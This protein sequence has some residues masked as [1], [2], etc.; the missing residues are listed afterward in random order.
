MAHGNQN[1]SNTKNNHHIFQNSTKISKHIFENKMSASECS[2]QYHKCPFSLKMSIVLCKWLPSRFDHLENIYVP[3]S[4]RKIKPS[5]SSLFSTST[6]NLSTGRSRYLSGLLYQL[7][8]L[9]VLHFVQHLYRLYRQ[10]LLLPLAT[11]FFPYHPLLVQYLQF[12]NFLFCHSTSACSGV[13]IALLFSTYSWINVAPVFSAIHISRRKNTRWWHYYS[14]LHCQQFDWTK[15]HRTC[16]IIDNIK[17]QR[18]R[19]NN[20]FYFR[21]QGLQRDRHHVTS[22]MN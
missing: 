17:R 6:I 13:L 5:T 18:G 20:Y 15:W 8:P 22:T 9:T 11:C 3:T 12:H 4:R 7:T 16:N 10:Q 19:I 14:W 2:F 21:Q 1:Y